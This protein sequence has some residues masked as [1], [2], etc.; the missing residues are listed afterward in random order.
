M[1]REASGH[2]LRQAA[3]PANSPVEV[4]AASCTQD[5]KFFFFFNFILIAFLCNSKLRT[6][7]ISCLI[8]SHNFVSLLVQ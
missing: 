3:P 1:K 8:I 2:H 7:L 5:R 4:C 6:F